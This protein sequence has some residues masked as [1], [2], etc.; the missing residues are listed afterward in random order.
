MNYV[1]IVNKQGSEWDVSDIVEGLNWKTSRIGKAGSLS[2]TLVKGSPLYQEKDFSYSNGDAVLVGVGQHE[3]FYGYIFSIDAGRDEAVKITA[4][5]QMRY[6]MNTETY[7]LTGVTA[8]EILQR[9]AKDF[10]LKL[11]TVVDTKYKIPKVS[12]DGKKLM[13]IICNAITLT[14]KHTGIDYCLYDR[15]GELCLRDAESEQID[16]IIGDRSLMTDYQVKT[17]IDSDTYNRIKLYRDNEKSGKRDIFMAEDSV[18]IKR[19]GVLQLYESIPEEMNTAQI[20]EKLDNLATLKNRETKSLKI[21][22]IGDIRVRAGMRVR[23]RIAEYGVDQA[24][25][26]DECSHDFDGADHTMSLDMRVV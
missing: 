20:A 25:L 24:L 21:E 7:V 16:L 5:D 12:E 2:F 8:T 19:W 4:Y 1:R 17:S 11:G 23:I 3:I 26:V 22:A 6:L 9:I 13:D 18:N 14:Y 15:F 10:E